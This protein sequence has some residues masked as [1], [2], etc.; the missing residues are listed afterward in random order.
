[1]KV[2]RRSVNGAHQRLSEINVSRAPVST[3][4]TFQYRPWLSETVDN[5]ERYI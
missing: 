4:N 2:E 3:G 1:M 5:T